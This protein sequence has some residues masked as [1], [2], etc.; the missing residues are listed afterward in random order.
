M[1]P[2]LNPTP[3]TTETGTLLS[4]SKEP[5]MYAAKIATKTR[6]HL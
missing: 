2:V 3:D 1:Q 5:G 6:K 4:I